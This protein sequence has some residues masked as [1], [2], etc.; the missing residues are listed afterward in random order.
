MAK[1]H[2]DVL[3]LKL[4]M[5]FFPGCDQFSG[6]RVQRHF[7]PVNPSDAVRGLRLEQV[8]VGQE[9]GPCVLADVRGIPHPGQSHRAQ[10]VLHGQPEDL[11]PVSGLDCKGGAG[12][13]V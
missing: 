10:R 11:R 3:K 13:R 2:I 1:F 12:V 9:S 8:P 7:P 5:I 6:N 4:Q